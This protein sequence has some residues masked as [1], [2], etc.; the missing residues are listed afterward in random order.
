[1]KLQYT[2][3]WIESYQMT[4]VY[5]EAWGAEE[6]VECLR[7]TGSKL[8]TEQRIQVWHVDCWRHP[9]VWPPKPYV[10]WQ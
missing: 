7:G 2:T 1:M 5:L 8:Y 6:V 3:S 9:K 4:I 10:V